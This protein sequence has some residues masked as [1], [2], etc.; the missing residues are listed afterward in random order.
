MRKSCPDCAYKHL[1]QALI[2]SHEWPWYDEHSDDDH[3]DYLIGHLAEAGDQIQKYSQFIADQIREQR[4]MLMREGVSSVRKLDIKRLIDLVKEVR[5]TP[6]STPS[7]LGVEP[8]DE[9]LLDQNP[10]DSQ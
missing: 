7:A 9:G 10:G 1:C 6:Q 8:D 3:L 4:L 2:I 5:A